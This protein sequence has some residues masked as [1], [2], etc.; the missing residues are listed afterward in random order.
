M[1]WTDL[2]SSSGSV[3]Q[4]VTAAYDPVSGQPELKATPA[5]LAPVPTLWR[6]LLVKDAGGLPRGAF[7]ASRI[8]QARGQIAALRGWEALPAD[9]DLETWAAV[10]LECRPADVQRRRQDA[11]R[12]VYRF[13]VARGGRLQACLFLSK[14][15]DGL[16]TDHESLTAILDEASD[17]AVLAQ[18]LAIPDAG[19]R[20]VPVSP[21]VCSCFSVRAATIKDAIARDKLRTV[22]DIGAATC[23]GT[24]CGSC[25]PEL[26][27]M[28]REAELVA[29]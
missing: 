25:Q 24:S 16:P 1:H 21:L 3:N 2:F 26:V 28:L 18:M 7:Y 27:R 12:G 19:V 23:A 4:L 15:A 20:R 22:A 10:L 13:V 8:P 29:V 5:R 14:D 9:G 6:G 17:S 11:S